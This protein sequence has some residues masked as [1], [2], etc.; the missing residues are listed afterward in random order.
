MNLNPGM[1][2][3]LWKGKFEMIELKML[4]HLCAILD[5][6]LGDLFVHVLDKKGSE[7]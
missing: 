2:S 7:R 6:E 3:R 4:D 5:C 1:A